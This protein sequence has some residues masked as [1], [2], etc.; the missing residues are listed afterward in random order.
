MQIENFDF[1]D[2]FR[3]LADRIGYVLPQQSDGDMGR[4]RVRDRLR[5]IHRVAA[6][7]FYENLVV[8]SSEARAARDYLDE[9]GIDVGL[10]RRFG[11]GLALSERVAWDGLLNN[12][13]KHGFNLSDMVESGL[14]RANES[15]RHYD[16]FRGRLM[17][18][19]LDIDGHVV[20]FGGR[21]MEQPVGESDRLGAKYLNS[22]ETPL[23]DKSR[24]LY[25]IHAARKARSREIIIVEGYMDVIA[26]HKAGYPHSV[27][28]LGTAFT[29]HHARLLKRVNCDSVILLFDRDRAGVQAVV[30]AIPVLLEAG[31]RVRCL[32]VTDDVKD[33]D[34]YIQKYGAARFGVLLGEAR[35]YAAFRIAQLADEFDLSVTEQR[36]SFTQAAA[37]VLATIESSIEADAYIRETSALSGIAPEAILSEMDKQRGLDKYFSAS[38]APRDRPGLRHGLRGGLK[39]ERGLAFARKGLLSILLTRPEV[40][41]KMKE[42]LSPEEMGD[43]VG[44]R[45]LTLAYANAEVGRVSAPADIVSQFESLEEQQQAA[46]V[47]RE[48]PSFESDTAMEKALNDMWRTVKQGWLT[49]QNYAELEQSSGEIDINA[50]ISQGKALRNLEKQYI[51][52]TNG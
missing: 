25:G 5:E 40:G 29:P 38:P 37:A 39:S 49:R 32:Q 44:L 12:L 34:D 7:F 23:F 8:D 41:A 2:A 26:L 46:E 9:R 33:P 19:I 52:I 3:F 47:F 6:R 20:G 43:E 18:P 35:H 16:R 4:L 13:Q 30:R 15:G 28:V 10:A 14:V 21:V 17:F 36:V 48:I 22:P 27:G 50:I 1:L 31:I 51:S 42:F 45:L 24:Q 11:L